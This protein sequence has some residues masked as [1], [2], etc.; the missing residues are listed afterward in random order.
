MFHSSAFDAVG[1]SMKGCTGLR[2]R[3]C[4]GFE[5]GGRFVV[6]GSRV[7]VGGWRARGM[8]GLQMLGTAANGIFSED[9]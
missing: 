1:G 5:A 6:L 9:T 4:V 3:L 7:D 8:G 2:M